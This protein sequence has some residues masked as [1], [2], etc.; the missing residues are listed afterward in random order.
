M[1]VNQ[2]ETDAGLRA[3][4]R[5]RAH[6]AENPIGVLGVSGPQLGATHNILGALAPRGTLQA[7]EIRTGVGLG[8]SLAPVVITSENSR[9]ITLPL[10]VGAELDQHGPEVLEPKGGESGRPGATRL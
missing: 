6:Q 7:G 10:C 3:G 5:V 2:K 1:Q 4:F 8:I 9:Q